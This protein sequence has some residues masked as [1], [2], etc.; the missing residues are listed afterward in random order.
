MGKLLITVGGQCCLE[1]KL[2]A[3]VF[4]EGIVFADLQLVSRVSALEM[5]KG[6]LTQLCSTYAIGHSIIL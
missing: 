2:L 6:L 5:Q 4:G 3:S 1:F